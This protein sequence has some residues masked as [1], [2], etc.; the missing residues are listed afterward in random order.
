MDNG[1]LKML[2]RAILQEGRHQEK[3]LDAGVLAAWSRLDLIFHSV[4][5]ALDEDGLGMVQESVEDR[6]SQGAVVVED[7]GPVFVRSVGCDDNGAPL[8]AL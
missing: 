1:D 4:A 3:S 8:I 5:F 2:V 7:L 6:G